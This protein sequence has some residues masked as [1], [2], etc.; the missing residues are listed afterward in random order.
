MIIFRRYFS[1][2]KVDDELFKKN[3]KIFKFDL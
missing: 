1:F 3:K 2:V